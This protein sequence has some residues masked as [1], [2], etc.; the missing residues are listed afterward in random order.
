VLTSLVN[1]C[2]PS[3]ELYDKSIGHVDAGDFAIGGDFRTW[4][5]KADDGGATV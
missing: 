3:L 5:R 1:E 2:H 4:L